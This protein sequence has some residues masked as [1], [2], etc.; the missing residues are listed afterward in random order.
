MTRPNRDH[1]FVWEGLCEESGG[2]SLCHAVRHP[3]RSDA[4]HTDIR[5]HRRPDGRP[6]HPSGFRFFVLMFVLTLN[7][8]AASQAQSTGCNRARAIVDEVRK[9]RVAAQPN[10][11][12]I[13]DKLKIA[14]QLC[15]TLGDSWKYAY[16]SAMAIGDHEAARIYRDRATFN[17]AS[18]SDC[19]HPTGSAAIP[20][21]AS[22]LPSFVRQKYALVIG[23]GQFRDPSI[24]TLKF[25]A[26][27]ARDF[28][29]VLKDPEHGRFPAENVTLLTDEQATRAAILNAMQQLFLRAGEDDLVVLYVSSHG[30]PAQHERGLGGIGYIVTHDTSLK[31]IWVDSIEYQDFAKKASMIK[32]R[33][34]VAFLDTCYSGEAS[35][36]GQKALELDGVGVGGQ[37]ATMFL[38]GE[39]TFVITSSDAKERSWESETVR[40]GYFTYYLI[41]ALRSSTDPPTIRQ[42]F[43][44]LSTKVR[45]AVA[46]EK[47]AAQNPQLHPNTGPA[48][49][50]IGVATRSAD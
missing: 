36:D 22:P 50:R 44:Y 3:L 21:S 15:P 27:D 38:S 43:D 2:G 9:L 16:C 5:H 24:P 46:K 10:H 29:D 35:R 19:G 12:T 32:A 47:Q 30:S 23:V 6:H 28:A 37:T 1:G 39:G 48:D 17:G 25:P 42:V 11:N 4:D 14:Q 20:P 33:R 31:N 13:L 8:A 49:L 18:V 41:E 26:K 7:V 45:V 34:K 40:N